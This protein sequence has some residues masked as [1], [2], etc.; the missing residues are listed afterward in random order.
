VRLRDL[1]RGLAGSSPSVSTYAATADSFRCDECNAEMAFPLFCDSCGTDY[2]ERQRMSAF[3][4]LGLPPRFD[5]DEAAMDER[6]MLL[7][8][9]LHPDRWQA[10]GDRLYRKA[11][12]AQSAVNEALKAVREPFQRALTLLEM[13]EDAEQVPKTVMPTTFLMAQLEL[14]EEIEDGVDG[15]RKRELT[16]VTRAEL[17]ALREQLAELLAGEADVAVLTQVRATIDRSHYWRNIQKALRGTA[18]GS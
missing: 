12:L 13:H 5:V 2:P 4:I 18:P 6:E 11:L 10:R 16:K 14:Q 8:R 7:S 9:R 15:E 1:L 17:K 3:G